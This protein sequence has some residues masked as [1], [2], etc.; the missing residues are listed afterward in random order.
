ME[1]LLAADA[2]SAAL[3]DVPMREA[4]EILASQQSR[5]D[6][7]LA[8]GLQLGPY[9][10]EARLGAGGMGEVYRAKDKRLRRTVA[11]KV[12]PP[13]LSGT[14]NPQERLER[15]AEAIS[16]LNHPHICT[17]Y[18]IG[19][20]DEMDY[21][22]MEL[23]EGETLS[24]RLK[25]GA[26]P[27]AEVMEF[28]IQIASALEAAHSKGII[29]RDIKPANIFVVGGAQV[30][31][32]D[33]GLAKLRERAPGSHAET[34]TM[35]KSLTN[36]GV[37][38]GTVSYMSPEQALGQRVDPRTDVWS[39][40]VVLYEMLSGRV[41]F[42]G[43]RDAS[44]LYSVVHEE[45]KPLKD[46]HPG[47]PSEL[48]QIVS[49]ALKKDVKARY[50]S[51]AE[52][53]EDLKR[54]R[55]NRK[56]EELT[57]VTPRA[58][59]RI[60]RKPKVA[61][62]TAACLVILSTAGAWFYHRQS[63]IH[64]ARESAIPEIERLLVSP[65]YLYANWSKAF[66][67][68]KEV[69][70]YIPGD[71]VLPGLLEQCSVDINITTAP[72]GAAV[73]MKEFSASDQQWQYLG[74]T[75]IRKIRLPVGY[76]WWRMQK[77]GYETVFA[78]A[79]TFKDGP[80][81]PLPHDIYRIL[82]PK[83]KI[84]SRMVRVSGA[85]T[86]SGQLGD[87]FIDKY[88]VTNKQYKEFVE[89]GGYRDRKYWKNQFVKAGKSLTWDEA[90]A[91]LVDQTGRPGPSTWQAGDYPKGREDYPVSGVSW[92]EAAAYAEYAGKSLPTVE[93]WGMAA[94]EETTEPELV[95]GLLVQRS[96]F[97]G[98]GPA[99]VGSYQSMTAYGAYDLPGNVREWCWN[100]SPEGRIVRGGAWN[101]ATY[102][103][104]YASQA[105][106]F[107]RSP[108]NGFRCVV[109]LDRAKIPAKA[110]EPFK[111]EASP[112]FYKHKPVSDS[113]FQIY[114]DQF[115][116]DRKELN[117]HVDWRKESPGGWVHEKVTIDAAY[118][119]ERLPMHLFLPKKGSPPYQTVIYFPGSGSVSLSSSDDVDHWYEFE[120]FLAF[121]VKNGRAVLYPVYKG[122]FERRQD[123]LVAI[124]QGAP[125]RQYTEFLIEF[126]K[127][128]KRCVD[129]LETRPDIDG[130]RLGY[131]G[132]SWGT[133]EA[134]VILAVEGRLRA[135][136]LMV[137]GLTADGRPEAD[138]RNYVTRVK[139]PTLMLNGRYDLGFPLD[140]SI[141]PMF[142][143]LG[144]PVQHKRLKL[145]DT[146]HFVP[147][148]ELIKESLTWLDRYLGPVK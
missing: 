96:N 137:A 69:E 18:D 125:T 79:Q 147:E 34:A 42:T 7:H 101:D 116:Y 27:L 104:G 64:W 136:I 60:L 38:V 77:E 23:L 41:P 39:L 70:K 115:S 1:S 57:V 142:D 40:G 33:F 49:R 112:D 68:T 36:T 28:A 102:L 138:Q 53:G 94:G 146:D 14:T 108:K 83:D 15:E 9:V 78:V 55:D 120:E 11:I 51:A 26:L 121:I 58:I 118:G 4:A 3:L 132:Y 75:P 84:P 139:V 126:V 76:F 37:I 29:H 143:L 45:P 97:K 86:D 5:S 124:H 93:H 12:L 92:Y 117:A 99:P 128:F 16:S 47:L 130:K 88:E 66:T 44:I 105:P 91:E 62:V 131:F 95:S 122:T 22:V 17:L 71:P 24:Q 113:V 90:L 73:Y 31:V 141:K 8:P 85:K 82:D 20:Q 81:K 140:T 133:I 89:S 13:H 19:R 72:P 65:E 114:K 145:Y 123:A 50:A 109:Y 144:T 30:K 67:L 32:L 98:E 135:S 43:D 61:I 119:N 46:V 48:Q 52:M 80:T 21:L 127:D 54:F 107:D 129:Y 56:A 59:L 87:F 134:P 10:I 74:A 25:R 63:K 106:A 110:F 6:L 100:E 111:V 148:N 35:E 103:L 2:R